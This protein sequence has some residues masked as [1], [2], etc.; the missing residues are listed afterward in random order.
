MHNIQPTATKMV[1]ENTAVGLAVVARP[2][3]LYRLDD[4]HHH[5]LFENTGGRSQITSNK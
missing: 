1:T 2:N 4:D 3:N 5:H